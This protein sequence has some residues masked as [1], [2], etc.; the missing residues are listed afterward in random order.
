[1]FYLISPLKRRAWILRHEPFFCKLSKSVCGYDSLAVS[2]PICLDAERN[3]FGFRIC[4]HS[5]K[6]QAIGFKSCCSISA[7]IKRV[8][9]LS[10]NWSSTAS[11]LAD[12]SEWHRSDTEWHCGRQRV[13]SWTT[14]SD[15]MDDGEWRRGRQRVTSWTTES[16]VMDDRMTSWTTESDVVMTCG[17]Q[18]MTTWMTT[19]YVIDD[20]MRRHVWQL[21]TWR[22]TTSDVM[23]DG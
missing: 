7:I 18:R 8:I 23:D 14:A 11:D 20:L 16:D 12:D 1:M 2:S 17:W 21:E 19:S 4:I 6:L 15:V 3:D 10:F 5:P 9:E 13:T 22:T